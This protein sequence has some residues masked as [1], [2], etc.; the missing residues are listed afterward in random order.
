MTI[1]THT[2]IGIIHSPFTDPA[3]T[4]IQGV[5]AGGARGVVEIFPEYADGLRDIGGFSHLI[6]LYHFHLAEGYSLISKPFIG[7]NEKGIFSIRHPRRPNH[8]GISIVRLD[9]VRDNMLAICDVDVLDGTPLLDI[10]PFVHQFDHRSDIQSGW[11]DDQH[12]DEVKDKTPRKL[13]ES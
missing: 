4:P 8:I 5:F 13:G 11:V 12:I 7:D 6:L 10:K 1:I 2:P 9:S 3:D